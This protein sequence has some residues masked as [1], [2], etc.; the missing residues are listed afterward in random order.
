MIKVVLALSLF[1]MILGAS[2]SPVDGDI[3]LR[4]VE[5]EMAIAE[6][7]T[8]VNP[9]EGDSDLDGAAHHAKYYYNPYHYYYYPKYYHKHHYYHYPAPYWY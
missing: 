8:A 3:S 6:E 9:I 1:A 5:R 2:S 7:P 4:P